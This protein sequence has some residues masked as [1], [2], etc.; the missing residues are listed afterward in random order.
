MSEVKRATH[1]DAAH[2]NV[3]ILYVSPGLDAWGQNRWYP[4]ILEF[5]DEL[6]FCVGIDGTV[7]CNSNH[8][9]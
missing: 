9:I 8:D 2:W 4:Q 7:H 5:L 1:E 3:S 6:V